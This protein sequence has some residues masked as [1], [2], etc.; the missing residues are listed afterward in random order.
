MIAPMVRVSSPVFVG[1][2]AEL[3]RL[4]HALEM[5]A[6]H[7]PGMRLV[8]GDAGIGKTRLIGEFISIARGSGSQVLVGDCLPMGDTGLPYAPFVGAMRPLLRSLA[9]EELAAL[10][11][12]GRAELSLLLPDLGNG[13]QGRGNGREDLPAAGV[14][15]ARLFEIVFGM[16]RRLADAQPLVLVLEDLHWADSSTR[17]LLLLPGPQRARRALPV[18]RQLP[19][20]RA[21]PPSSAAPAARRAPAPR[22]GR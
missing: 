14:A 5:A 19:L 3:A 7:R 16:L 17:D 11:G 10:I 8:G 12:P 1:R 15:Q 2:A 18:H 22:R 4:S 20:R 13:P 6:G 9:P 21:P